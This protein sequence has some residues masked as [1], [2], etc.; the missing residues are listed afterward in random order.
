MD[1]E[2]WRSVIGYEGIYD[3]SDIGNVRRC[4]T[5]RILKQW[6][7]QQGRSQVTLRLRGKCRRHLVSHLVAD[8]FLPVKGPTD[9]VVRHLNDIPSD[10][11]VVNLS[12]GTLLDNAQDAIRNGKYRRGSAHHNA[13]LD[14]AKVREIRSLY[15]VGGFSLRTLGR[16]FGIDPEMV[17]RII[18][19]QVWKHVL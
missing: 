16:Q 10:N 14:E 17:R 2:V 15:A 9:T 8:A 5:G 11:R 7:D 3:V 1:G 19:R 13:K 18:K 4:S 6:S 12:R